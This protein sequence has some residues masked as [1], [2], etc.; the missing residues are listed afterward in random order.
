MIRNS[1]SVAKETILNVVHLTMRKD[2]H[3]D[4]MLECRKHVVLDFLHHDELIRV[5]SSHDTPT[6]VVG[7]C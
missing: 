1:C 6:F 5:D 4:E 2:F 7:G 3:D